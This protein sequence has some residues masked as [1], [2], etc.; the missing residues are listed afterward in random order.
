MRLAWF[1]PSP[2]REQ[3]PAAGDPLDTT[4]QLIDA[5]RAHHTIDLINEARAHD[6]VWQRLRDPFD[7]S[8][9]ELADIPGCQFIWPY[10]VRYP[11][12]TL[13]HNSTLA[14]SRAAALYAE[15][16]AQDLQAERVFD[17]R[18]T[19]R[20]LRVPLLASALVA[21]HHPALAATLA[22]EYPEAR[23]RSFTGGF[24]IGP[25]AVPGTG[26]P[27]HRDGMPGV[28]TFGCVAPNAHHRGLIERAAQRARDAGAI[29]HL[30]LEDDS[31]RVV[32][33]SDV[34]IALHW[35]PGGPFLADAVAALATGRVAVVLDT[36]DTA[37]WPSLDP[38]SWQRRE[39]GGS[40]AP[41]CIALD[42]L[43]EE[44]S[45]ALAM[46][47]LAADTALRAQ[48][49]APA[50]GWWREH[51]TVARAAESFEPL[52]EEA[53]QEISTRPRHGPVPDRPADW[54]SHLTADG[55]EAARATLEEFGL[56]VDVLSA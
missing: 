26:T 14:A 11:G 37:D 54:P 13:L 19:C 44:H 56:T 1:R 42:L 4:A 7:L 51:F 52:L 39:D 49:S 20:M 46:R 47:R 34:V 8:V 55:T 48:L 5:L 29:L 9:Y 32:E 24:R 28:V 15:R 2:L 30:L 25:D 40:A 50:Q 12:L 53:R 3:P 17:G 22:D 27:A 16:R 23:I 31:R 43:D 33:E 36:L 21:V 38:R 41:V 45:L 10:L 6:M 18:G 35:P